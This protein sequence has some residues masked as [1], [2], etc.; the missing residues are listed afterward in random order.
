MDERLKAIKDE[1][2]LEASD[3]WQLPQ[4]KQWL[5]KHA[6]LE[7]VAAKAGIVFDMPDV[8]ERDSAAGIAVICVT[9]K[10]NERVEWSFGEASPKNS[11]TGYPWAIAE[12][13]AKDRVIL[14]LIGIHG[15]VYSEDEMPDNDPPR[16]VD[17][18][19][20]PKV[21]V[22]D[23]RVIWGEL[24]DEID[25]CSTVDQ[26]AALWVSKTF[27][28]EMKKLKDSWQTLLVEHKDGHKA[29]LMGGPVR[30]RVEPDFSGLEA[31][32]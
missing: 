27:Q 6:A 32:Q 2:G 4:N 16:H 8:I 18:E 19:P 24:R 30:Q 15:L 3:M 14:K 31:R 10:W 12:K 28:S 11:K 5:I 29:D 23:Q 17:A 20:A 22:K 21:L 26:L 1:Y 25:A 7:V 9:G 13:R